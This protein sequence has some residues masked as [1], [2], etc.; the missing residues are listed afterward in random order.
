MHKHVYEYL[1]NV[2][3]DISRVDALFDRHSW[4]QLPADFQQ[5]LKRVAE[6]RCVRPA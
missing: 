3:R 5:S 1:D 6:R 4:R 2:L